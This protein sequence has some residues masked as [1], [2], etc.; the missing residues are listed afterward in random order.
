MTALDDLRIA[1]GFLTRIPAGTGLA[2]APGGL[3][4]SALWFPAVGLLVGAVLGG[5]RLLAEA[6]GLAP[7]PAT[8]LGVAAAIVLTGALHEDGLADVADAIGVLA[9]RERRLEIMRDSR[10]GTFG[11]V[12][13]ILAIVLTVSA[14]GSLDGEDALRAAVAGHVLARWSMVAHAL[15]GT[16]ARPDGLGR[17][18][19]VGR[20]PGAVTTLAAAA[21]VLALGWWAAGAL[22]LATGALVTGAATRAATRAFG[23]TTGDTFG[24]TGK[25]VE[26]ATFVVFA[27]AW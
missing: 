15:L 27:A 4:R 3:A 5:V 24:A 8:V 7:T 13:L 26:V 14:L 6:T 23:G 19:R 21:A 9:P 1:V 22:A 2:P 18:L 17:M 16:P 20:I 25:L 10:I 12:A 11:A